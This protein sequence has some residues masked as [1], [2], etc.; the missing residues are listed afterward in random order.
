MKAA[1]G[2]HQGPELARTPLPHNQKQRDTNRR[3]K[4]VDLK[5]PTERY[6]DQ[7]A[8]K[9]NQNHFGSSLRAGVSA[10]GLK[11]HRRGCLK[12]IFRFHGERWEETLILLGSADLAPPVPLQPPVTNP[13]N[14]NPLGAATHLYSLTIAIARSPANQPAPVFRCRLAWELRCLIRT[15]FLFVGAPGAHLR[16]PSLHHE[17]RSALIFVGFLSVFS[18]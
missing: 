7:Q 13:M 5:E 17:T 11:Q 10:R 16:R 18:R 12:V 4:N 6:A 3:N 2:S 14:L 15:S 1:R 8:K 9:C